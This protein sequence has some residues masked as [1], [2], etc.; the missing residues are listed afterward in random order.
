MAQ[1]KVRF[2]H[3]SL[4]WS[5][6]EWCVLNNSGLLSEFSWRS[7]KKATIVDLVQWFSLPSS[8]MWNFVN[9]ATLPTLPAVST[10]TSSLLPKGK[11][12][13][14]LLIYG[15]NKW[16]PSTPGSPLLLYLP[17]PTYDM[18]DADWWCPEVLHGEHT[19]PSPAVVT[20]YYL[21]VWWPF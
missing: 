19:T 4:R 11:I 21:W 15:T 20:N 6:L 18:V 17:A 13:P 16:S 9:L 14:S 8:R 1:K 7:W 12:P 10:G 3:R 5:L 2:V